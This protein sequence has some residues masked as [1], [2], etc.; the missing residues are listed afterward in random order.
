MSSSRPMPLHDERDGVHTGAYRVPAHVLW[1]A[2]PKL[3]RELRIARAQ[4]LIDS[5]ADAALKPPARYLRQI[6]LPIWIAHTAR[7]RAV[8]Y[9]AA[10]LVGEGAKSDVGIECIPR[11]SRLH[12][13]GHQIVTKT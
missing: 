7:A 11:W 6:K 3:N 5:V 2:V 1:T 10:A 8:A 12:L 9:P 13:G 4:L